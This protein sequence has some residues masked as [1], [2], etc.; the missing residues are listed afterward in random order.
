MAMDHDASISWSE[1]LPEES[2]M[3]TA[4]EDEFSNFLEFGINFADLEGHGSANQHQRPL[5]NADN[6][7]PTSMADDTVNRMDTDPTTQPPQYASIVGDHLAMDLHDNGQ[8]QSQAFH[9]PHEQQQQQHHQQPPQHPQ[10]PHHPQKQT[11]PQHG[12]TH[13]YSHGQHVIPPT[14]NSIE[15]HGG[16]ARYPQ[17]IEPG[18]DMYDRYGQM[19]EDQTA[20][21][22]PL[23]SPAMTP[24]ETQFR[25]PEYTIPG[26]YFTPLTSPA[27]EAQGSNPNGYPF[28]T[29]QPSSAGYVQSPVDPNGVNAA[30][31]PSS[32]GV[33]RKQRR[34][35]SLATRAGG[36]AAK[37]S[38]SIQPKNRRKGVSAQL[39][40]DVAQALGQDQTGA[41]PATSGGSSL[42]Y[43]SHE[44]SGQDSVSPEPISE[45]LMPPPALPQTRKSPAMGPQ[46]TEQPKMG[47]PATPATLMRIQ[48][49][50]HMQDPSGQFSGY[51]RLV[52]NESQDE[53]ME[54]VVLPE[55]VTNT[56]PQV[57]R[58][59]TSVNTQAQLPPGSSSK[60]TPSVEP[61]SASEKP[62]S[63]SVT[64][65][66]HPGAMASPSG[67][68][69]KKSETKPPMSRKRQSIGSS[70]IS[71]A[72]RP[73]ISP[74]IQPLVRGDTGMSSETSALYLA[75][76]SNYQHI[77]DGTVLPGV[78]YPET[79][80]ENLSSKRTNHKLAEQGRR[81]R[82]NTALKEIES[83]LP[84]GFAQE[85]LRERNEAKG[86]G[87]GNPN[88]KNGDNQKEKNT[89]QTISKAST[90]EM[91]IDYIKL[92]KKELEETKA[93]LKAAES[94]LAGKPADSSETESKTGSGTESEA[95]TKEPSATPTTAETTA[96]TTTA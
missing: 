61:R 91:A 86:D 77:L 4:N 65:S 3:S 68:V 20:F 47:E 40:D 52:T 7:I 35:P 69:P 14:P 34:R 13:N 64:P 59:D 21:Y 92:L 49:R 75:S 32:P 8:A 82:I 81:N 28:Q 39:A 45:P 22:T 9:Y 25:M 27:L 76:K 44:S 85:R 16:A 53:P 62:P 71:P 42:H 50:Q 80:A 96:E 94:K 46:I 72:L 12:A 78:S 31:A 88:N 70:H 19:N 79:L 1:H 63:G 51:A 48:N 43:G 60:S 24:L 15:L 5:Q 23:V 26:E 30:S 17:R 89:H 29:T 36:R 87:Q 66:P 54:D 83:L 74:S 67:P 55:A 33:L 37:A 93:Q 38:P 11:P 56:R 90:V 2:L 6:H 84:P 95:E 18:H 73:R 58:I 41:R 57:T 10:H